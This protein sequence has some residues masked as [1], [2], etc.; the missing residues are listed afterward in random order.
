M[1]SGI[2]MSWITAYRAKGGHNVIDAKYAMA[3]GGHTTSSDAAC[4]RR[5]RTS[6]GQRSGY[7]ASSARGGCSYMARPEES[8]RPVARL[9]PDQEGQPGIVGSG[10][11]ISLRG[12]C[13]PG[14]D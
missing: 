6:Y 12:Q 9:R 14:S 2:A 13:S 5:L 7:S 4:P 8:T 1:T 3:V 10:S 11:W